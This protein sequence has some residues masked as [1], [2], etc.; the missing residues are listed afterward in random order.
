MKE[1]NIDN[2]D[3]LKELIESKNSEQLKEEIKDLHPAD[4]AELIAELDDVDYLS[5]YSLT[6]RR[7][8]MCWPNSMRTSVPTCSR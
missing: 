4:I 6:R 3:Q 5:C 2:I 7:Q 1:F 8:P